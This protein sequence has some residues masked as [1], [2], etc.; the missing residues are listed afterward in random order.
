LLVVLGNG[1]FLVVF[2]L[3]TLS[4]NKTFSRVKTQVLTMLVRQDDVGVDALILLWRRRFGEL[5]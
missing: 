3:K 4:K 1:G 2:L 5:G